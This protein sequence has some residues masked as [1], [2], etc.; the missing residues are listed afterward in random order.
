MGATS[1]LVRS[2]LWHRNIHHGAGA[3]V[4]SAAQFMPS[5]LTA[6]RWEVF[7]TSIT[8]SQFERSLGDL[9]SSELRL[10]SVN[11]ILMANSLHFIQ[12]Q[13]LL[14]RKRRA[15]NFSIC[16]IPASLKSWQSFS[17][18]R[19]SVTHVLGL[20]PNRRDKCRSDPMVDQAIRW[21]FGTLSAP[22]QQFLR[23]YSLRCE[24]VAHMFNAD[25]CRE[26]AE[27]V[28]S[29]SNFSSSAPIMEPADH[30]RVVAIAKDTRPTQ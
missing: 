10:P 30:E 14:L 3:I 22:L 5:I 13:Q 15:A 17:K 25:L 4:S 7:Q 11:G 19:G 24:R 8:E 29:A 26:C 27:V 21:C 28:E 1:I 2:R 23:W 12:D 18:D 6:E 9:R 20:C 16:S